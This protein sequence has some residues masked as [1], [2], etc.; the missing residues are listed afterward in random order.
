MT[1]QASPRR[2]SLIATCAAA[3]TPQT[4]ILFGLAGTFTLIGTLLGAFASKWFLL[5]PAL[6]AAN[7]L[8]MA[9]RGWCPMSL[10]LTR[11]NVG[12]GK[13]SRVP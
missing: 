5:L 8:L 12:T 10:L 9:A 7:Q 6:V 3:S 13:A 11:L 2:P 1:V 4:R